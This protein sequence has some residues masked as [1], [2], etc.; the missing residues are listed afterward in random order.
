MR[1]FRALED[2]R[3]QRSRGSG[4]SRSSGANTAVLL[5]PAYTNLGRPR[6]GATGGKLASIDLGGRRS[7]GSHSKP[8]ASLKSTVTVKL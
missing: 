1:K 5:L 4:G 8:T 2:D 6:R 7:P 3:R